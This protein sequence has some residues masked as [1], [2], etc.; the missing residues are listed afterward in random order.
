[1]NP[2]EKAVASFFAALTFAM[3]AWITVTTN[4]TATKVAVM[5]TSIEFIQSDA[6]RAS[7][8]RF[9]G[10]EAEDLKRR[11]RALESY[12]GNNP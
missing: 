9:T 1:M 10:S 4:E 3:L 6:E 5:E 7:I 8:D 12:H 2:L 11:I